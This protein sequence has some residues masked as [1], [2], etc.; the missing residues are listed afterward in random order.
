MK[1]EGGVVRV[2]VQDNGIGIAPQYHERIFGVFEKVHE[3]G[4]GEGTGI[5]LALV[6]KCIERMDGIIGLQSEQG[7]GTTFWFEL[8]AA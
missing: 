3:L 2:C 8:P 4:T 7:R 5:G 1:K 6:K